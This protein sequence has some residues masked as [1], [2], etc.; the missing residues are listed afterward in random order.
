MSKKGHRPAANA[1]WPRGERLSPRQATEAAIRRQ[2]AR[3]KS[4][5]LNEANFG[6]HMDR[7][8]AMLRDWP[9][10]RLLRPNMAELRQTLLLL[11]E[12]DLQ[13]ALAPH[14]AIRRSQ[15]VRAQL[16][17]QVLDE[18]LLE[19]FISALDAAAGR[20]GSPDDVGAL[21]IMHYSLAGIADGSVPLETNPLLTALLDI[22][23]DELYAVGEVLREAE[24]PVTEAG[25]SAPTDEAERQRARYEAIADH[26]VVRLAADR[27]SF[28]LAH[29]LLS[30]LSRGVVRATL[31]AEELAPLM[32]EVRSQAA[33]ALA[34]TAAGA[35]GD[36]E[37]RVQ[38]RVP[39]LMTRIHAF[40][41]DP[42]RNDAFRRVVEGLAA[43][44][45][46]AAAQG[47]PLASR[48]AAVADFAQAALRPLSPLRAIICQG[49]LIRLQRA[50]AAPHPGAAAPAP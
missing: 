20:A 15:R 5:Q 48:L 19:L 34:E 7:L 27:R 4:T 14:T 49:N 2:A 30:Y 1:G 26:P 28:W 43:E 35:P 37:A 9:E 44:A 46:E 16:L 6:R 3:L 31:T 8:H 22:S 29:R 36:S 39:G 10:F 23:L 45:R 24:K 47:Q 17:T 25:G 11:S 40:A 33:E 13:A 42:A 38:E 21:A 50:G 12:K 41:A 18:E 32:A